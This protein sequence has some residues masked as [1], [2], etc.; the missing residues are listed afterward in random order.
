M[1]NKTQQ[2]GEMAKSHSSCEPRSSREV[3]REMS[4]G[5]PG[6]DGDPRTRGWLR[7]ECFPNGMTRKGVRGPQGS[8]RRT[9]GK[10]M[11]PV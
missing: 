7:A 8:S 5:W 4:Q 10:V 11:S 6:G 9:E 1:I 3:S 2:R